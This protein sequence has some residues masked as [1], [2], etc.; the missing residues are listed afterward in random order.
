[1]LWY[2]NNGCIKKN[3]HVRKKKKEAGWWR[4][5]Q[6][7]DIRGKNWRNGEHWVDEEVWGFQG[8][9]SFPTYIYTGGILGWFPGNGMGPFCFWDKTRFGM[10]SC[11]SVSLAIWFKYLWDIKVNGV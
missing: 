3:V 7:L 9:L 10:C 1:L 4:D 11:P 2:K 6:H 5:G 8:S